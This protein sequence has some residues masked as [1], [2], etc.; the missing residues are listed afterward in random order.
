V[1]SRTIRKQKEIKG[2]NIGKKKVKISLFADHM[3]VYITNPQNSTR[4][5]LYLINN[6]Y[7]VA[8]FKLTL[9]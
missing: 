4:E 1:L 9:P 5:L 3:T 2:I 6:F 8:G 7:K